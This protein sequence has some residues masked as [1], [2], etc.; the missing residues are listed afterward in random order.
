MALAAQ[1]Q[2]PTS[3]MQESPQK[4]YGIALAFKPR[5]KEHHLLEVYQILLQGF[6]YP[7][8]T[9]F[10]ISARIFCSKKIEQK[11]SRL[12]LDL[13]IEIERL[14]FEALQAFFQKVHN[15]IFGSCTKLLSDV[16]HLHF[17]ELTEYSS[18]EFVDWEVPVL[19]S[20]ILNKEG[21]L[22]NA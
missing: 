22:E 6:F 1:D 7:Q 5:F 12:W 9:P 11:K 17:K 2:E 3:F 8:Q 10:N 13:W 18:R 15:S 21:R 4:R 14:D 20:K 16:F 19:W